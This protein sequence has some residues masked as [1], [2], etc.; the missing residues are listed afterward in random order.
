MFSI[1]TKA[2]FEVLQA[3]VQTA[4]ISLKQKNINYAF[5]TTKT[6]S[7]FYSQSAASCWQHL[8]GIISYDYY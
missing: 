4:G 1:C 6:F 2:I 3:S 8:D 5:Q 7:H